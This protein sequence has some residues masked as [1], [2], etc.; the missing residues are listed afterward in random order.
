MTFILEDHFLDPKVNNI[1]EIG[2][3]IANLERMLGENYGLGEYMFD[4]EL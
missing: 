1:K 3:H 4:K 2:D